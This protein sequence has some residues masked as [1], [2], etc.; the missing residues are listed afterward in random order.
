MARR[1]KVHKFGGTSVKDASRYQNVAKIM[2]EQPGDRKA[3]V[4]SAMKGVTDD[5]LK[6]VDLAK[7]QDDGYRNALKLVHDRH[8]K[9]VTA[10]LEEKSRQQ[11]LNVF[12]HDVAELSEILRGVWLVKNASDKVIDLVSGMGEVW[13]AQILNAYFKQQGL[14]SDWID[15]RK[16][17]VVN[18]VDQRVLVDWK[19][20]QDRIQTWLPQLKTELQPLSVA[21]EA[22]IRARFLAPFLTAMRFLFG[23]MLMAYSPPIPDSCPRPWF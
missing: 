18:H 8:I 17:L 10:L 11:L 21:T 9:E 20:S 2:S 15:A 7:Q 14:K 23:P 19:K 4:V 16:I 22:I 3:V 13:S 6:I 12:T 5:L 1:W